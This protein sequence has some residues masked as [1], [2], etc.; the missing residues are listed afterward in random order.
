MPFSWTTIGTLLYTVSDSL[1][2]VCIVNRNGTLIESYGGD[3]GSGVGQLNR[4]WRML[5]FGGSMIVTDDGQ[6]AAAAVQRVT[7]AIYTRTDLN[8]FRGSKPYR[9]AISED[10][11][12]LFVSYWIKSPEDVR[13]DV[14]L[15]HFAK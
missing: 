4:P 13:R 6:Q 3:Q 5:I 9:M 8:V 11:T 12:R 1:H 15:N 14:D 7:F 2:R 10:G